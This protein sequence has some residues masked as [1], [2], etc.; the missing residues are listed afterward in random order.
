VNFF[1]AAGD[2]RWW[3]DHRIPGGLAF[4]MN[5]VGHMARNGALRRLADPTAKPPLK[6]LNGKLGIDSLGTALKF[7]ML[8]ING[9]QP[10]PGG[11]ATC[12]RKLEQ[13][14]YDALTPKCPFANAVPPSLRLMDYKNYDGWYHT[15]VTV[16]SDYFHPEVQRPARVEPKELDWISPICSTTALKTRISRPP[17]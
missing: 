16:P 11:P 8:T 15:D 9:A 2:K 14:T 10:A 6:P 12:L 5:S 7:A 13:K 1:A 17:E 4:S 3:H